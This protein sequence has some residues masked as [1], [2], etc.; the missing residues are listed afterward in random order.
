M[1]NTSSVSGITPDWTF[2]DRLRKARRSVNMTSASFAHAIGIT[3][4]ALS[5]YETDRSTPRNIIAMARKVEAVTGVSALWLLDL[6]DTVTMDPHRAP[7]LAM[8]S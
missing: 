1:P 2:G 8:A 6:T 4:P 5:Q 3:P 7:Q